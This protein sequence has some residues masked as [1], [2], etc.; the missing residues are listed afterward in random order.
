MSETF[1]IFVIYFLS[2]VI[3]ICI[4]IFFFK[5]LLRT[6]LK[7]AEQRMSAYRAR[8]AAK[9]KYITEVT[10][11]QRIKFIFKEKTSHLWWPVS[12]ILIESK[13]YFKHW[14]RSFKHESKVIS[15]DPKLVRGIQ[16]QKFGSTVMTLTS[17]SILST[18]FEWH[19]QATKAITG[20]QKL[21]RK[22][23]HVEIKST[24]Q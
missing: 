1:I 2:I 3:S 17:I 12:A 5:L 9:K 7:L 23:Q 24:N 6:S 8:S 16:S 13:M 19:L 15:I 21:E 22:H 20:K 4:I 10:T 18:H 14:C 11:K